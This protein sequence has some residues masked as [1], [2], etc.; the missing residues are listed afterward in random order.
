[1]R[2][3]EKHY[4]LQYLQHIPNI[5][6][7][8]MVVL[9]LFPKHHRPPLKENKHIQNYKIKLYLSV[10]HQKENFEAIMYVIKFCNK[11]CSLKAIFVQ[12]F[13]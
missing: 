6:P 3:H 9:A 10:V 8:D 2:L 13:Q 12:L 1:M 5:I 11:M 4:A 7:L